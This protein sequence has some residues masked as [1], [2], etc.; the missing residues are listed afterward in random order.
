MSDPYW[1]SVT[2]LIPR[3]RGYAI[4]LTRSSTEADDLVQEALTRAWRYRSGF[5]ADTNL[6][7]WL[8]KIL[9]NCFHTETASRR[10]TMQDVDGR[11]AAQ[12]SCSPEQEWFLQY[13]DILAAMTRLTPSCREALLLVVA[14]DLTYDEAALVAGCAVGTMKSRVNRARRKLV[15]LLG[16]FP[17]IPASARSSAQ[18]HR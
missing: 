2:A 3:L 6:K 16:D 18:P 14:S 7:A 1:M 12:L 17:Q 15:E 8:Y 9:R 11:L 4:A 13:S 5:T 10:S